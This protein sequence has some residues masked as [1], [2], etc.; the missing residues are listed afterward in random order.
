MLCPKTGR[1]VTCVWSTNA[2]E[3]AHVLNAFVQLPASRKTACSNQ[4]MSDYSNFA[5]AL[6]SMHTNVYIASTNVTIILKK[7]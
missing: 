4:E 2:I 3:V 7:T 6:Q 1:I 5:A